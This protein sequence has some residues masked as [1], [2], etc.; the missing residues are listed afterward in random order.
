MQRAGKTEEGPLD[1]LP[2]EEL[3]RRVREEKCL[4][5]RD[6][7]LRRYHDRLRALAAGLAR[8]AG[9]SRADVEDAQQQAVLHF[10]EAVP[11][12]RHRPPG[13]RRRCKFWTFARM[14]VWRRVWNDLR[15][16]HRLERHYD[17]AAR[18]DDWLAGKSPLV[19]RDGRP[20]IP[21]VDE[22]CD[23]GRAAEQNEVAAAVRRALAGCDRTLQFLGERLAAGASLRAIAA[24]AGR[25]YGAVRRLAGRLAA[26]VGACLRSRPGVS[27]SATPT[28]R[29]A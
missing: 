24:E 14:V 13:H 19:G 25:P 11:A 8:A 7:L 27:G 20:C 3:A 29:S 26:Y 21:P 15:G 28:P 23:P 1:R 18:S 12:Y 6:E 2:D 9:R 5:A 22:A 17:R 10:L 4:A 16:Q